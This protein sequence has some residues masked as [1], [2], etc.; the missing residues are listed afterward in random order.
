MLA[1]KGR[2]FFSR[3]AVLAVGVAQRLDERCQASL[4]TDQT[5]DALLQGAAH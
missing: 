4:E 5:R 1:R 2:L 3:L